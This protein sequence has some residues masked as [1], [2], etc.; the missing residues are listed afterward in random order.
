MNDRMLLNA[1]MALF[2]AHI[3]HT[4]LAPF[5]KET[6]RH[7]LYCYI[8]WS[9]YILFQYIV[10]VSDAEYPLAVLAANIIL[11]T[12]I[13]HISCSGDVKTA[14]FRSGILYVFWMAVELV[15]QGI[16]LFV[17]TDGEHFFTAGSL[18]SKIALYIIVQIYKRWRGHDSS[19]PLSFRRW[20]ELFFIPA[21]SI[22]I[23][24]NAYLISLQSDMYAFFSLVSFL[25]ILINCIIFDVYEKMGEQSL[26]ER[27][28]Q[29]YEQ[30]IALCVRQAEER[31]EAYQQTRTLRHDLKGRLIALDALLE[32]DKIETAKKE[33]AQMLKLNS[34]SKHEIAESG[35]LAL[36]ALVNYK[37]ATA[38]AED[39]HMECHLEVPSEFFLDDTDLCVI[40]ENLLDNALEAVQKLPKGA[41]KKI[42]LKIQ[43]TK[44][45][46]LI[47]VEN[48]YEG[49][50]ILDSQGKIRSSKTRD[51]GIGLLSVKR[52]AEKY[53]GTV[54]ILHEDKIFQISVML[55][56]R[57]N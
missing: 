45:V 10:M 43:L 44:G 23:I 2:A 14:I 36:D 9:M 29:A 5:R 26:V 39:I 20:L 17:G 34:L 47:T 3:T 15:V 56:Q 55:L 33:I 30:E 21:S 46:I 31:E 7:K 8:A 52:I 19:V 28:N 16:L 12:I 24:Y 51:H 4:Y 48:P 42:S 53:G 54:S 18:I 50:I 13:Q 40:L 57:E 41:N 49:E 25:M 37:Y 11:A 32:A 35:N 6:S 27:Q 38:L 1:L 22:L